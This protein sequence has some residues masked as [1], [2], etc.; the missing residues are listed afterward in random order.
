MPLLI[1]YVQKTSGPVAEFGGGFFSTPLLHWL[2]AED[3]RELFTYD[4]NLDISSFLNGFSSRNHHIRYVKHWDEV[5][6]KKKWDVLF[7]DHGVDCGLITEEARKQTAIR[8][9][10]SASY[11]II[12]D[13]NEK[14]F[15]ED[16][17]FWDNFKYKFHWRFATPNTSVVSNFYEVD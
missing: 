17:A 11:I 15:T 10:N 9:K 1:K 7:I 12:H 3:R 14:E 2:C 16:T 4:D 5:D 6:T 13:T 8:F